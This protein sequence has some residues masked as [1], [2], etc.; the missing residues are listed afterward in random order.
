MEYDKFIFDP[1]LKFDKE[2]ICNLPSFN[3][4]MVG[5]GGRRHFPLLG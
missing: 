3:P 5:G 2:D 1:G 4:M